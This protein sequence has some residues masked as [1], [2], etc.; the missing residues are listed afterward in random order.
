MLRTRLKRNTFI[1]GGI[2][3]AGEHQ[4]KRSIDGSRREL[5]C[6]SQAAGEHEAGAQAGQGRGQGRSEAADGRPARD[7][8]ECVGLHA[9]V[10][11]GT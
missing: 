2:R 5:S 1:A 3:A 10:C 9:A 4:A 8:P 11:F 6:G 7:G